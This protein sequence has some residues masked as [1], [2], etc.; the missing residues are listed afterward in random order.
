MNLP[1]SVVR[2]VL[3]TVALIF[4]GMAYIPECFADHCDDR[5]L[6]DVQL[7]GGAVSNL[8]DAFEFD[9][10]ATPQALENRIKAATQRGHTARVTAGFLLAMVKAEARWKSRGRRGHRRVSAAVECEAR[11]RPCRS[12]Y[13]RFKCVGLRSARN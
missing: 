4:R 1:N 2:H 8:N 6:I 5:R 12:A 10:V 13:S 9:I 7:L 11:R 3:S